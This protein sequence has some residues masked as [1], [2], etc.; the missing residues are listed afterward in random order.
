MSYVSHNVTSGGTNQKTSHIIILYRTLKIV[1][2]L[3]EFTYCP[4]PPIFWLPPNWHS[5][6][7]CLRLENDSMCEPKYAIKTDGMN[8]VNDFISGFPS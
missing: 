7:T 8:A 2:W 4:A 5:L 3:V 6:A 1:Q